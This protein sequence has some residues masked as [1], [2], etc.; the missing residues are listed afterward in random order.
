MPIT[1]SNTTKSFRALVGIGGGAFLALAPGMV[2]AQTSDRFA[3][4]PYS[5]PTQVST[6][7]SVSA[8]TVPPLPTL[9]PEPEAAP[10]LPAWNPASMADVVAPPMVASRSEVIAPRP[11]TNLPRSRARPYQRGA[12]RRIFQDTRSTLGYDVPEAM[13]DAL[14][15]VDRDR[16]QEPFEAVLARVA[17]DLSRA[18]ESDPEWARG[19]AHEIRNLAKRLDR[20][21]EPP[22]RPEMVNGLEEQ[23]SV[24]EAGQTDGR[25][26][27]PRPIWPGTSGRP[28]AQVRPITVTT[29]TGVQEGPRALGVVAQYTPSAEDQAETQPT[30]SPQP[31]QRGQRPRTTRR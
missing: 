8:E 10:E 4:R 15:W 1:V 9:T 22:P 6:P 14:P 31:R 23:S 2:A 19:S 16:K 28:E 21:S 13:A 29:L 26:F 18:S 11:E 7:S 27:R 3:T 17:D 25:P 30:R 12:F 5:A 20:L 24:I